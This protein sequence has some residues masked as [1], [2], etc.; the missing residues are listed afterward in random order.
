VKSRFLL[1][2]PNNT[3]GVSDDLD[4]HLEAAKALSAGGIGSFVSRKLGL[5]LL[6]PV[7]PRSETEWA[8][9]THLLDRDV[10]TLREGP[11]QRLDLQLI[12]M[13]DDAL[14]R[15]SQEGHSVDHKILITG[16]SASGA[17]ANRFTI[18]HPERVFAVASGGVN[19]LLMLPVESLM[20]VDLLYPLGL[21]DY[22]SIAG[23]PFDIVSWRQVLQFIYMGAEDDND[24]V[25][26]DDGYSDSE[27]ETVFTVLGEQMQ[28]DRWKKCQDVYRSSGAT[29]TF[30]TYQGIG[31]GTDLRINIELVDFFRAI[32]DDR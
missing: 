2:E 16:F 19:G 5:P 11:M 12:A 28:P 3:A 25:Q 9:Y 1:V 26:F 14:E 13:V 6:V 22:E 15:L 18:L 17:F 31:H 7:F 8:I 20:G 24:A 4:F 23:H 21:K 29:V 30:R 27:R 32:V 10:M